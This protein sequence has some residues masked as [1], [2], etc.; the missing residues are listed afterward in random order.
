[1]AMCRFS[2]TCMIKSKKDVTKIVQIYLRYYN[3]HTEN[4]QG[5]EKLGRKSAP[6]YDYLKRNPFFLFLRQNKKLTFASDIVVK[7]K[8]RN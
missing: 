7:E 8:D 4:S 6:E 2:F 1:M 5:L 3:L